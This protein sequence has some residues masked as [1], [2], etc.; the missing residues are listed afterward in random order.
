MVVIKF[1][2]KYDALQ[3]D[4]VFSYV[5]NLKGVGGDDSHFCGG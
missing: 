1:S 2:L 5:S 4:V 3:H